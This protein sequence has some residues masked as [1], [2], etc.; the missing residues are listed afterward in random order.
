MKTKFDIGSGNL[1]V[2]DDDTTTMIQIGWK[3]I[4]II[5]IVIVFIGIVICH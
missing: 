1:Q 2:S 3:P 4:V 5:S